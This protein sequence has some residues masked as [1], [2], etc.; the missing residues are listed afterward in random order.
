MIPLDKRGRVL[1]NESIGSRDSG[2]ASTH[3]TQHPQK[4]RKM[5]HDHNE[6]GSSI[7]IRGA[8]E[9]DKLNPTYNGMDTVDFIRLLL[10]VTI[11]VVT[12]LSVILLHPFYYLGRLTTVKS[13]D[14]TCEDLDYIVIVSLCDHSIWVVY[15]AWDDRYSEDDDSFTTEDTDDTC[16]TEQQGPFRPDFDEHWA[17]LPGLSGKTLMAKVASNI[18]EW[19]F[20]GHDIQELN[21]EQVWSRDDMVPVFVCARKTDD[22][23]VVSPWK[24]GCNFHT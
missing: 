10:N 24:P 14:G 17:E 16:S 3:D 18:Y 5:E 13:N 15:H 2:Y 12:S 9:K 19:R 20:D 23:K 8:R 22:A 7:D 1:S 21:F 11:I 6:N 4:K